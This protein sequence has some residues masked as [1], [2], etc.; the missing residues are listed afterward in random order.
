MK[1][2]ERWVLFALLAVL[3]SLSVSLI[4]VA[5]QR[6]DQNNQ[7]IQQNIQLTK[8]IRETK[9]TSFKMGIIAC[10]NEDISWLNKLASQY[11]GT[12]LGD[13]FKEMANN[14]TYDDDTLNKMVEDYMG[15]VTY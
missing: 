4:I 8:T 3:I 6:K 11:S 12:E 5:G 7:L 10:T 9:A 2:V 1:D 14:W 15:G 13:I